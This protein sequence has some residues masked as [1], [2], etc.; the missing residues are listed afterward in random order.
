MKIYELPNVTR[1]QTEHGSH[2]EPDCPMGDHQQLLWLAA[3]VAHDTG[4]RIGIGE[5]SYK[6]NGV[7]QPGM[8]SVMV[9]NSSTV[10]DWS[11]AWTYLNGVSTGARASR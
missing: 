6:R 10:L 1:V 11:S 5:G 4:L 7:E 9:G 3:V 8:Y 2:I